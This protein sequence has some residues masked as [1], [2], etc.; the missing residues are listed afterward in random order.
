MYDRAK[1]LGMSNN[2]LNLKEKTY[3]DIKAIGIIT[4]ACLRKET[5]N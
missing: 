4:P 5:I 1:W 3:I 2:P